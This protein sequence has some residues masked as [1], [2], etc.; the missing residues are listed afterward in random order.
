[1]TPESEQVESPA[2][3]PLRPSAPG[4]LFCLACSYDLSAGEA[5]RCPECGAPFDR[6]NPRTYA[7]VPI[8]GWRR[9]RIIMAGFW[10]L[11]ILAVVASL[12]HSI[13]PRPTRIY[14]LRVWRWNWSLW[15]WLGEEFGV[16]RY[17]TPRVQVE[18]H[19]W[20]G[21]DSKFIATATSDGAILWSAE[22]LGE[23]EYRVRAGAPGVKGRDVLGAFNSL[24]APMFFGVGTE[25]P[26]FE[27]NSEPF[28][29]QGDEVE[30]FSAIMRVYRFRLT[31]FR[32]RPD[33]T[34][35]WT[36]DDESG[37]MTPLP[38]TPEIEAMTRLETRQGDRTL[39]EPKDTLPASER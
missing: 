23:H 18:R 17:A 35:V 36:F 33:Q 16:D 8:A 9:S 34:Y 29:V 25:A 32:I 30:V 21:R 38:L 7:R 13:L 19:V 5:A 37:L 10:L 26:Q 3:P 31:P 11:V 28:E 27:V 22:R 1:M 6:S 4:G 20:F 2:S 24:K 15:V 12:T 39:I 14:D